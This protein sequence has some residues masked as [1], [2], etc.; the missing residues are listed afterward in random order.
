MNNTEAKSST[1]MDHHNNS[2]LFGMRQSFVHLVH[3]PTPL[4][5][6]QSHTPKMAKGGN[7][8]GS[9]FVLVT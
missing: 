2:Q 3:L 1:N 7:K 4:A 9:W 8:I 6:H 5:V